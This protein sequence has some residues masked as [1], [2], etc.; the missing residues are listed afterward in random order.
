MFCPFSKWAQNQELKKKKKNQNNL[1]SAFSV[2]LLKQILEKQYDLNT[3]IQLGQ[4]SQG[5]AEFA[6]SGSVHG[7]ETFK[8][9]CLCKQQEKKRQN[10]G[11]L[12]VD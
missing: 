9:G 6:T 7:A 5:S 12:G 2:W 3:T 8:A 10:Q 4:D 1:L 11:R